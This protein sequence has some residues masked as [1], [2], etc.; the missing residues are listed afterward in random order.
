M[1]VLYG[2]IIGGRQ[3]A[4]WREG[5]SI[6]EAMDD[7]ALDFRFESILRIQLLTPWRR[8]L[9]CNKTRLGWRRPK[10]DPYRSRFCWPGQIAP[11][12]LFAPSHCMLSAV[13]F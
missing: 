13:G 1:R 3:K 10:S 9:L 8:M 12:E 4:G 7:F 2:E 5:L 11:T 6:E